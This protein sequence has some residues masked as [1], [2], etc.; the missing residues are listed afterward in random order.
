MD[1]E[2][3]TLHATGSSSNPAK[4]VLAAGSMTMGSNSAR[5]KADSTQVVPSRKDTRCFHT[6]HLL[7]ATGPATAPS[8]ADD[9]ASSSC[10][11]FSREGKTLFKDKIYYR[12]Q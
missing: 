4:R 1:N 3:P 2:F 10:R 9:D 8:E 5:A 11:M 7:G 6:C 12:L